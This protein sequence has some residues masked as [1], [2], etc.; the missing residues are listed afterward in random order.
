M[1]PNDSSSSRTRVPCVFIHGWGMNSA[2]WQAVQ[3]H[4]PDW[5]DAI[6]VDLPGHGGMREAPAQTLDDYA[7]AAAAV[8]SRPAVWVG[9]SMG[10]LVAL[11]LADMFPQKAAALF[12]PASTPCFVQR[13][14]WPHAVKPEVFG[15]F[16]ALLLEDVEQTLKRFLALQTLGVEGGRELMQQLGACMT[17]RGL[18]T[19][20]A[21][22][23]GLAILQQSDLRETLA[24]LPQPVGMLLGERDVLVPAALAQS[25]SLLAPQV[26]LDILPQAGHAPMMSH[27]QQT[28]AALLRFIRAQLP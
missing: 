25:L 4:L 22:R 7:R 6:F 8:V 21:L 10:G 13:E 26:R 19:D 17:S 16:A 23:L 2:V 15:Q 18:A 27:P 14:N 24:R 9:W 1:S 11:R 5:L 28:V 3:P 12:L 20:E